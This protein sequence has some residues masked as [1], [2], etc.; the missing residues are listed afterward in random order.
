MTNIHSLF[1]HLDLMKIFVMF[2]TLILFL[3]NLYQLVNIHY[4]TLKV[5]ES[6]HQDELSIEF[7]L[8]DF[9]IS[10]MLSKHFQI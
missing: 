10:S 6:S 9:N 3:M 2:I 1:I 7:F 8:I 5:F 4:L